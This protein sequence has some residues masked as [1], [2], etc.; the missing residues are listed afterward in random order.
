MA[1][2]VKLDQPERDDAWTANVSVSPGPTV[3]KN[4]PLSATNGD[5]PLAREA[6]SAV[7]YRFDARSIAGPGYMNRRGPRVEYDGSN[8]AAVLASWKLADDERLLRTMENL[9]VVVP[10]VQQVR[11][12][13]HSGEDQKVNGYDLRFDFTDARDVPATSVSEGTLVA[14]ALFTAL[15]SR[16]QPQLVLLDDIGAELH[17]MAQAQL[18]QTLQRIV[19]ANPNLQI[20]AST[21]SPYILDELAPS[22][23][24]VFAR[25]P[26]GSAQ[27][28]RLSE[29]PA[30]QHADGISSG[31]LWSLDPE[32]WVLGSS[33]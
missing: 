9:R 18:M 16:A 12:V 17:P 1:F 25:A 7:L 11:L 4:V 23:I 13:P 30:A 2:A 32:T 26:D 20:V 8:T 24:C 21:H 28:K 15:N 22:D 19:A 31:Q 5:H 27:M 14:L 33:Q 10:Q 3:D 6:S 29:H